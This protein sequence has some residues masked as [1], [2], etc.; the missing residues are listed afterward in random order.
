MEHT[1]IVS[2]GDLERYSNITDSQRVIPELIWLLVNA[3][4]DDLS[5]CRIP[6]GDNVNQPGLDGLVE[7]PSGFQQYVPTDSSYW[8]IGTNQNPIKKATSDFKKRTSQIPD[9]ERA[10]TSYVFV[11][12]R[13]GGSGGWTEPSQRRWKNARSSKGW[14]QISILDGQHLTDWLRSFPA[15]GKWLQKK[16]GGAESDLGIFTP[17]EHWDLVQSLPDNPAIKNFETVFIVG[18]QNAVEQLQ[19]IFNGEVAQLLIATE[20]ELDAE[21]FV[22]AYLASLDPVTQKVFATTCLIVKTADA[23]RSIAALKTPHVLVASPKVGLDSDDQLLALA[24]KNRHRVIIPISGTWSHGNSELIQLRSPSKALLESTLRGCGFEDT[25]A[26]ELAGAGALSLAG[27]RRHLLGLSAL[28]PYATWENA[29]MLSASGLLG[30]WNDAN[31]QDKAVI[32]QLVG[33]PYGEWI[34][35]AKS[36]SLRP[37]TPLI[38]RNEIWRMI[39]RGEAWNALGP[40]INSNDLKNFAVVAELV[41]GEIDPKFELP[42]SERLFGNIKGRTLQH[43]QYLRMGIAETLALLGSRPQALTS[44][45]KGNVV[46]TVESV[47]ARLL[48]SQDW[49]HWCSLHDL[50]PLLAEASPTAFLDSIETSLAHSQSPFPGMYAQESTDFGGWN[51]T[52]GLLWGLENLA[53]NPDFLVRTTLVLGGLANIDPGGTWM[54]RP[55]NSLVD[56][57]L[58]W[59]TQT[60]ASP[61]L[62]LSAIRALI[63]EYPQIGWK[64]VLALL[65]TTHGTTSGTHKP[66]WRNY[67]PTDW[68]GHVLEIDYYTQTSKYANIAIEIAAKDGLKLVELIDRI[69]DLP[70]SALNKVLAYLIDDA[71]ENLSEEIKLKIWEAL[72]DLVGKHRNFSETA[73]A[74]PKALVDDLHSISENLSPTSVSLKSRRIFSERDFDLYEGSGDFELQ[75]KGLERKRRQAIVSILRHQD[76]AA[77]LDFSKNVDSPHKVGTTLGT[78]KLSFIDKYLMPHLL[79]TDDK[80]LKQVMKGFI[81]SRFFLQG[82]AWVDFQ[83]T[84]DWTVSE[85]LAFLLLLPPTLEVWER[86]EIL[87][88]ND[89]SQYWRTASVSAWG[90]DHAGL[91]RG[92]NRLLTFGRP[93]DALDFIYRLTREDRDFPTQYAVQALLESVEYLN[94]HARIDQHHIQE[95]IKWLQGK[96]PL[97][98]KELFSIE[99]A[100]L[101]LLDSRRNGIGPRGLEARL[102]SH[103]EFYIEVLSLV[104][105]SDTEEK[106]KEA[107]SET[108]RRLATNA[109]RLLSRW[110]HLP[111]GSTE[112]AFEEEEFSSWI[113]DM[114]R[115]ALESGRFQIAMSQFGHVLLHSP[116][117]PDGFWMNKAIARVLDA[118]DASNMRDG[119][120]TELFNSRGVFSPSGGKNE[121][122]IAASYLAKAKSAEAQGFHRISAT[123]KDLAKSY[124]AQAERD[125]QRD[126]FDF[127]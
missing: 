111:G 107:I 117:D 21:D 53:W 51:Y 10:V 91:V 73:W 88:G 82:L 2:A 60:T 80:S 49:M 33:K 90:L 78:L 87:L 69:P 52:S 31:P 38:F 93:V 99:W 118:K 61:E 18:R 37:D 125:E 83:L 121:R 95:I 100:Y 63:A 86:A 40:R 5:Q 42:K 116:P 29:R 50:L 115:L 23:W 120:R 98:S 127:D 12:P 112:K 71:P 109:Y 72:K 4:I 46:A 55:G 41:L 27:L 65:P 6:Y 47:V 9:I 103:P 85:K 76:I 25:K 113:T 106:P 110:S 77:V 17:A 102:A 64:T 92:A 59:H 97:N 1:Q 14:R 43:S 20:S 67:I 79:E 122:G 26:T 34:E 15:V 94:E 75:A 36:A 68:N 32:E 13:G 48:R 24:K 54:N 89:S 108:Q 45:S 96:L 57:F 44:I 84:R 101:A 66:L 8:E 16:I 19:R 81:Y 58:P 62:C 70:E 123:L 22:A 74:M 105:R 28:P 30:K 126:P 56:I 11:T 124:E 35:L 39:C 114:K 3:S 119:Y 104:F 7:T